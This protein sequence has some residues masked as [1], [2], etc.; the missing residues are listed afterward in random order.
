MDDDD[1][2]ERHGGQREN[3]AARPQQRRSALPSAVPCPAL[4]QRAFLNLNSQLI[5]DL[6]G[7]MC[8]NQ[9]STD[10]SPASRLRQCECQCRFDSMQLEWHACDKANACDDHEPL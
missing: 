2:D 6:H 4:N 7:A 1:D 8:T 9:Q 3:Q 10:P 5:S